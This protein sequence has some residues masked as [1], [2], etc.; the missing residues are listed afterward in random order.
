MKVLRISIILSYVS[1]SGKAIS[2]VSL[3]IGLRSLQS[4]PTREKYGAVS[5]DGQ[6]EDV[7]LRDAVT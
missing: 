2:P 5:D 1:H 3:D 7:S 6:V 4:A